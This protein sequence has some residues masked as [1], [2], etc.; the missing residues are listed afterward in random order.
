MKNLYKNFIVIRLF[1][2]L[3]CSILLGCGLMISV[4]LIPTDRIYSNIMNSVDFFE[5]G[6]P[7]PQIINGYKDSQLD[8]WTDTLMLLIA[9]TKTEDSLAYQAMNNA[10]MVL[11]NKDCFESIEELKKDSTLNYVY[12]SGY[13]RYWHGY[14]FFLKPL[15]YV[16]TYKQCIYINFM[17]QQIAMIIL[18]CIYI[19]KKQGKVIIPLLGVY[20]YLNPMSLALSI[21]FSGIW[22]ITMVCL[23]ILV[24]REWEDKE[25]TIIFM[26]AGILTSFI[27]LLTYPLVTLGIPLAYVILKRDET[28]KII[29][30]IVL[31][32]K[33]SMAW[34]FGYAGMWSGKWII[35]TLITKK[36]L[37]ENAYQQAAYRSGYIASDIKFSYIGI[38]K[39]IYQVSNKMVLCFVIGIGIISLI[40][41]LI[42]HQHIYLRKNIFILTAVF[43]YPFLWYGV[44]AN[45]S[46]WHTFFTYRTFGIAVYVILY[47]LVANWKEKVKV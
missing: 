14:L 9:A 6:E 39:G 5:E 4:Y 3:L 47:A 32:I 10:H 23:L 26:I 44:F 35:G 28:E 30:K 15:L 27:D 8:N 41:I 45:H 24:A 1:L 33:Y 42:R 29:K 21:Q 43:A 34:G 13:G 40:Y 19:L 11:D 16:F 22:Y 25:K 17:M 18:C 46:Y 36:N 38:L 2:I 31:L 12:S 7:Y 20:F 37:I